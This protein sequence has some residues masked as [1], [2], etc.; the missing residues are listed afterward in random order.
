MATGKFG[1]IETWADDTADWLQ[2]EGFNISGYTLPLAVDSDKFANSM[3]S[4]LYYDDG[5]NMS[6]FRLVYQS[7]GAYYVS[8]KVGDLAAYGT[9]GQ[10]VPFTQVSFNPSE[11]YSLQNLLYQSTVNP[12]QAPG[13]PTQ[14]FY[15][16]RPPV[17]YVKAYEVVKG[18][19]ITGHA[20]AGSRVTAT[21]SLGIGDRTFTY[22]RSAIA[23]EDGRYTLTVPYATDAMKG[24]GYSSDV[25][26]LSEY[27]I[28]YG[29]TTKT[30][31]VPEQAVAGGM[32]I[33]VD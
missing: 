3:M 26:P 17:K 10:Y 7:P 24:E 6:H 14:F 1:A 11:N 25:M 16:S 29:N 4:R 12:S 18:A 22:T 13:T 31:A 9:G 28:S 27:T 23:G 15:D 21:V 32:T 33:V 5:D 20:P 30:L 19:A 8:T 2:L